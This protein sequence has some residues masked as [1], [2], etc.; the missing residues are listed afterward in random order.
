MTAYLFT[1]YQIKTEPPSAFIKAVPLMTQWH[2]PFSE[3]KRFKQGLGAHLQQLQTV[4]FIPQPSAFNFA[5]WKPLNEPKRFKL[6]L[7]ADEQQFRAG[8]ERLLPKPNVTV[9]IAA[10]ETSGDVA[11]FGIVVYNTAVT[12]GVDS[13][14]VSISEIPAT[15][16]ASASI[17]E[18]D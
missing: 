4:G 11:L 18:T 15:D 17:E 5:W 13:V 10:T 14:S 6:A 2:A 3:P 8:P 7:R 12:S 1:Q 16:G 9:T